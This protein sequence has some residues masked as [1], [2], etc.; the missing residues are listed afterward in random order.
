MESVKRMDGAK[1]IENLVDRLA[2]SHILSRE[3]FCYLL[4]NIRPEQDGYLYEKARKQALASYGN[5]VFVR[6]LIEFT[7]YCKNDCYYCGI[8]RSN[9]K[10]SRYRLTPEQVMD[11][12]HTGYGLGFR[13]FVLQGG[14]DPWFTDDKIAYLVER[15]R[16][17]YPDC[18]I[19]LSV[20]EKE[21]DTY[22]MWFDAGADR[23]LLRHETANP[24]HYASLHPPQM[25][26]GH[27]K[28]CLENLKRIGYQTGCGIMVGAPYQTTGHIAEDLEYMYGLQPQMVGIGPF[29]PHHDTPFGGRPA[30]TL[31]QTLLL[32]AIV[33]LMLPDVLLPATTA[34][35]TAA[36]NGREQGV[37]AGANV[38]MP[39]LSPLDVRKK[40]MLYDN[41]IS[42]GVEAAANIKELKQRMA[43]IGY[44]VVT[45][46]GDFRGLSVK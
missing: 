36:P 46:R 39:N 18:A 40:Y 23:Y 13:T 8:R 7:N 44:E 45:D 34:L 38:V 10:A 35:G 19:T 27:R 5:R 42:T 28:E 3:E 15:I 20:G 22:K 43:S 25:S 21:Y 41:K 33:R 26:S 30:G 29:I 24:C 9:Q 17:G 32:L 1:C 16:G 2:E 6:G 31:R 11:C 14:E 4:E 37:L 12:C